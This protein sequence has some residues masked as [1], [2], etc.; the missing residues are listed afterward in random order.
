MAFF[1]L[2]YVLMLLVVLLQADAKKLLE[3]SEKLD[4]L[5]SQ[6]ISFFLEKA[7]E[8][9]YK[10][11]F[12]CT[13]SYHQKAHSLATTTALKGKLQASIALLDKEKERVYQEKRAKEQEEEEQRER[14]ILE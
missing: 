2:Q 4:K 6:E 5:D 10:R 8:C 3:M 11:D 12:Y 13:A 7:D 1:R 9:T 14:E